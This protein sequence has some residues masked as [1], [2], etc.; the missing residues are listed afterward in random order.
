[1]RKA[2]AKNY[3]LYSKQLLKV[4][5]YLVATRLV[6]AKYGLGFGTWVGK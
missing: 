5:N 1:M 3:N 4:R 2:G 6:A